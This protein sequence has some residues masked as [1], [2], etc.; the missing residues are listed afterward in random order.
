MRYF[1]VRDPIGPVGLMSAWNFPEELSY[2]KLIA[3]LV[4]GGTAVIKPSPDTPLSTTAIGMLAKRAGY[5]DSVVNIVTAIEKTTPEVGRKI[6]ED[7]RL[8]M[9]SFTGS[10]KVSSSRHV[11]AKAYLAATCLNAQKGNLR[12]RRQRRMGCIRLRRS[13]GMC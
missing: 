9:I 3:A 2:L 5:A 6:C 7:P 11:K 1:T 12:A 4:T 10:T 8:K 13:R